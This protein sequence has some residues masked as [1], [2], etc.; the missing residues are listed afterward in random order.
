MYISFFFYYKNQKKSFFKFKFKL[1]EIRDILVSCICDT[2]V[3]GTFPPKAIPDNLYCRMDR[4]KG[5]R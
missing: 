4:E 2:N 3:E 1:S 5:E